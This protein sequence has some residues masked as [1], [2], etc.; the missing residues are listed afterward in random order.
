MEVKNTFVHHA[1]GHKNCPE[2]RKMTEVAN[3]ELEYANYTY[4]YLEAQYGIAYGMVY[5]CLT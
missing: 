3:F 5:H 4:D 2:Q 1:G